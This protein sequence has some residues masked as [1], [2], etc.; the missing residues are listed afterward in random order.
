[1]NRKRSAKVE[2]G[3]SFCRIDGSTMIVDSRL[4][5]CMPCGIR[6]TGIRDTGI[7]DTGIIEPDGS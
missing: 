5:S 3:N 7:R 2:I 1:L 6:D 4:A